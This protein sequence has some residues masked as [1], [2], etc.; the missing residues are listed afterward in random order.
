LSRWTLADAKW[1]AELTVAIEA[2]TAFLHFVLNLHANQDTTWLARYTYGYRIHHGY[3]G[4][5]LVVVAMLLSPE[6]FLR[7]WLKRI[8]IAMIA[9]D[10]IHHF[11]VLWLTQ[12]DPEF[13]IV[14]PGS[15]G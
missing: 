8:G 1:I 14:Y 6:S 13:T 9:S 11:V 5:L 4:L 3:V 2:V 12:G 10:L 7:P 15:G